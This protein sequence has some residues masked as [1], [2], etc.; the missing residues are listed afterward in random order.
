MTEIGLALI[1]GGVILLGYHLWGIHKREV[2]PMKVSIEQSKTIWGLWHTGDRMRKDFISKGEYKQFKRILL[3]K[4][5]SDAFNRTIDITKERPQKIIDQIISLTELAKA[6]HIPI[7]WYKGFKGYGVTIYDP[8]D[9]NE[10]ISPKAYCVVEWLESP[11]P[12]EQRRHWRVNNG[13]K[14]GYFDSRLEEINEIWND[15]NL[16]EEPNIEELT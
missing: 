6:H 5:Y 3:M 10:P 12:R 7:K 16:S 13:D 11:V 9:G 1:F 8:K 15:K 4:P 2:P 14:E